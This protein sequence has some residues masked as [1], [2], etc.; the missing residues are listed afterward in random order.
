MESVEVKDLR[1]RYLQRLSKH[2]SPQLQVNSLLQT[3]A[4]RIQD[5]SDSKLVSTYVQLRMYSFVLY[6]WCFDLNTFIPKIIS[7]F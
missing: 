7:N 2:F 4:C 3:P 1:F 6:N 5:V